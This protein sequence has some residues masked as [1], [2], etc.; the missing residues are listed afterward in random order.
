MLGSSAKA[1]LPLDARLIPPRTLPV[2]EPSRSSIDAAAP[3]VSRTETPTT[4]TYPPAA[5]TGPTSPDT[6][7]GNGVDM[8]MCPPLLGGGRE[9]EAEEPPP[10]S[11]LGKGVELG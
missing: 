11:L 9:R 10:P 7:T 2:A 4:M 8:P 6:V 1:L 3:D 5:G